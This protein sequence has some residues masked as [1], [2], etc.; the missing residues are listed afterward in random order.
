MNWLKR[1]DPFRKPTAK[2][3]AARD[4]EDAKRHLLLEQ[5]KAEYHQ[6][7]TMFYRNMVQ[8]LSSYLKETHD[9]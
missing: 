2:E 6:S 5:A 9:A 7:Q 4:L 1:F 3:I 8:R